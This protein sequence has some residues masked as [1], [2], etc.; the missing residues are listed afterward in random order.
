[1][2][3]YWEGSSVNVI[4]PFVVKDERNLF[5][6]F[7]LLY[8]TVYECFLLDHDLRQLLVFSV[9]TQCFPWTGRLIYC[10]PR[11]PLIYFNK[12]VTILLLLSLST[13]H[14]WDQQRCDN[15]IITLNNL[16]FFLFIFYWQ[17]TFIQQCPNQLPNVQNKALF[18]SI[19]GCPISRSRYNSNSNF[20]I[21]VFNLSQTLICICNKCNGRRII[22]FLLRLSVSSV[23]DELLG[24]SKESNS[25]RVDNWQSRR[26]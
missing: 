10:V 4:G 15:R 11:K 6:S 13:I 16:C 14:K 21:T 25:P 23:K 8:L 26:P 24:P 20:T 9:A 17:C 5:M 22:T 3:Y 19:S 12:G 18:Q 2:V 7:L 1:M